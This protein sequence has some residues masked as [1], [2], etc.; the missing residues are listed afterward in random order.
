MPENLYTVLIENFTLEPETVGETGNN[1]LCNMTTANVCVQR[2][3]ASITEVAG[4]CAEVPPRATCGELLSV[5]AQVIASLAESRF[6]KYG[7]EMKQALDDLVYASLLADEE[8]AEEVVDILDEL[9]YIERMA[10]DLKELI[11]YRFQNINF[12]IYKQNVKK[13]IYENDVNDE[14]TFE[15]IGFISA[16][17]ESGGFNPGKVSDGI[18]DYGG[19][20]YGIPQF[21]TT[22][23]S[24]DAFVSWLKREYP[25]M[26]AYFK[27][28]KAGSDEF[29]KAWKDVANDYG[30]DFGYIQTNYVYD[31]V[32]VV[33]IDKAKE[34]YGIDYNRSIAL[35]EL[36][37]STGVQ[38][39]CGELGMAA[40]GDVNSDMTDREIINASYDNK[41]ANYRSY[42]RSSS[43]EMQENIKERFINEREDVLALLEE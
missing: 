37:Y 36:V 25:N 20:S 41:I 26:G 14:Y 8:T 28:Y 42:F 33:L 9:D 18:G 38:F 30:D 11:H 40:L 22:Q 7:N 35:R 4:L 15:K 34:E 19:V 29:T 27:D 31:N 3:K 1:F 10:K 23:G 17:Y 2:A 12:E 32:I 13:I 6:L 39:D 5:C 24:A 21:S 16:I 43:V